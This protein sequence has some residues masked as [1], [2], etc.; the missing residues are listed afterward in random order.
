MKSLTSLVCRQILN[1]CE[2]LETATVIVYIYGIDLIVDA[3]YVE[4]LCS[5]N[6]Q[7]ATLSWEGGI[8]AIKETYW[9]NVRGI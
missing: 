9:E 8:T 7:T 2:Y 1:I 3:S 5:E 6:S 4:H